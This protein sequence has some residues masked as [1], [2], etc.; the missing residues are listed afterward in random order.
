MRYAGNDTGNPVNRPLAANLCKLAL[1]LLLGVSLTGCPWSSAGTDAPQVTI[2]NAKASRDKVTDLPVITLDY[3]VKYP[4]DLYAQTLSNV[5][6]L[7][8]TMMQPQLTRTRTFHGNPVNITGTTVSP[9]NGQ[10]TISVPEDGKF[11]KGSFSLSCTLASDHELA[12]S[13]NISVDVPGTSE[14]AGGGGG[15]ETKPCPSPLPRTARKCP[16]TPDGY[17]VGECTSGFCWDGGPQGS[18]A[19]KQEETVP[20]SGRTYTSDLVCSEGYTAERDPCTNV[21]LRCVKK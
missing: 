13:N 12:S 5:P 3:T 6:R 7:T 10:V 2:Q 11:I 21:I 1:L 9:Q 8:C 14:Q 15:P 16:W 18:L 20:N 19:C 4:S 17:S